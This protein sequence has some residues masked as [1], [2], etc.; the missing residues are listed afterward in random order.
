LA[1]GG[2]ASQQGGAAHRGETDAIGGDAERD[3][4]GLRAD[5]QIGLR[6][7]S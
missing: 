6:R 1:G 2:E 5:G 4:S 3:Q 7:A